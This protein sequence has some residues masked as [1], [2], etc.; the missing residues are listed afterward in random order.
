[1]GGKL[2]LDR[3]RLGAAVRL[4]PYEHRGLKPGTLPGLQNASHLSYKHCLGAIKT[5][6]HIVTP[7]GCRNHCIL[8]FQVRREEVIDPVPA[9]G[10]CKR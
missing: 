7:V 5:Q 8:T 4:D 3:S 9:T 10:G 2:S 6:L 1:M